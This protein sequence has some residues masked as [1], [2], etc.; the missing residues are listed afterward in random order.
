[1]K[2]I[3]HHLGVQ[4]PQ[5]DGSEAPVLDGIDLAI[6]AGELVVL[7]GASGCGKSTLLNVIAGFLPPSE[8]EIWVEHRRVS[9]P[10]IDRGVVLQTDALFP[11]LNARDNV[12]FGLR[13]RSIPLKERQ[14]RAEAALELVGLA[15]KGD[16]ATWQLSGGQRQRVS[17]ARALLADPEIL[18]MDEPLG[19]LDALTR[20][21]MQDL[22][23]DVWKRTG[24]TI[25]FVTHGLDEA[26]YLGTRLVVLA[27][28]PGRIVRN[29]PLAFGR[30]A[31]TQGLGSKVKSLPAFAAARE[32]LRD[33]IFAG[34]P[35]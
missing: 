20:E 21:Q 17:L 5:P 23:L 22:V 10:G 35:S 29:E 11:W 13:L 1:M 31:L 18:L 27:G 7:L 4:F 25:L 34:A 26:L 9:G 8:G 28:K 19:A 12:G 6:P 2:L 30:Q 16:H 14:N 3:I 24:K 15:G 32:R 33:V